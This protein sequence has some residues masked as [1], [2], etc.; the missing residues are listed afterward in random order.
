[1][2]QSVKTVGEGVRNSPAARS[3]TTS[4]RK[5]GEMG[6]KI[7]WPT[8]FFPF[9]YRHHPTWADLLL[10]HTAATATE[11]SSSRGGT[12]EV[13]VGGGARVGLTV[14][15]VERRPG[16]SESFFFNYTKT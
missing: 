12:H 6:E 13:T 2:P 3:R 11:A 1:M 5:I 8:P 4:S 14:P 10:L 15:R 7:P 16:A 9:P